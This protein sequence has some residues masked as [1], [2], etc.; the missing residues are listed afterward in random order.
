MRFI[1]ANVFIHAFLNLKRELKP[2]EVQVKQAARAMLNRIENG[3]KVV[4]SV[5]HLS[6]V[7]NVLENYLSLPDQK[8]LFSSILMRKN[9]EVLEVKPADYLLAIEFTEKNNLG[10]NDS[11]AV[12]LMQQKQV[13]EI[14]SFDKDFDSLDEITRVTN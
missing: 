9:I 10:I 8:T 5:V 11:L 6:E 7:A 13:S 1:D 4:T 2:S 12:V 3:E 14:Y